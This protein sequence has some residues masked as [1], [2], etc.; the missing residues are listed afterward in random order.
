MKKFLAGALALIFLF[1][2]NFGPLQAA[3]AADLLL[4]THELVKSKVVEVLTS[5]DRTIPGT[6][7]QAVHQALRVNILEGMKK[8]E[9]IDVENDRFA[10]K[11]GDVF[12]L[13]ITA[14]PDGQ[15][16]YAV[17]EPYRMTPI[18][19]FAVFFL[20]L[21]VVFGGMQGI[22]GLLS[23]FG[24][25]FVLFYVFL[26]ELLA[27]RSPILL[28]L[29]ISSLIIILGSYITH[30][31]NKTTT[32]AVIGMIITILFTGFMAVY[33]VSV[34]R[35]TGFF[36]EDVVYLHFNTDGQI[37]MQGLLLGG[38]L[39]G[40]LGVLYDAAI[41]QAVAIEELAVH[42]PHLSRKKLFERAMRIGREHIGALIDTLALAYVGASLPLLLLFY[43]SASTSL[44]SI[45]NREDF[46]TEIMRTIIGSIGLILAV[47]ITSLVAVLMLKKKDA[48]NNVAAGVAS[49]SAQDARLSTGP[50]MNT[51]AHQH[52]EDCDDPVGHSHGHVCGHVRKELGR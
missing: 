51:R 25:L 17:A 49:S 30:G 32:S 3:H 47:P 44:M 48:K 40:L 36:S 23:L 22:R 13:Q 28:S 34:T 46:A 42:A 38:I 29:A 8:G 39:I 1:G 21:V 33:A 27:G 45:L 10:L 37:N 16:T 31:F 50:D 4:D 7:I 11:P 2:S 35:L 12:Y 20:I 43:S 6:E 19:L 9:T 14:Y 52:D 41:S 24:S 15:V 18:I 26:P 5:E